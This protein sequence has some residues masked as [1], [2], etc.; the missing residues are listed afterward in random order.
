MDFIAIE[1][2][3]R[4]SLASLDLEFIEFK[5]IIVNNHPA[6]KTIFDSQKVGSGIIIN[7][8]LNGKVYIFNLIFGPDEKER[9]I[10]EFDKFLETISIK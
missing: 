1:S 3:I 2:D 6:L 10:Q 8:P 4:Y 5:D 7:I 9:C